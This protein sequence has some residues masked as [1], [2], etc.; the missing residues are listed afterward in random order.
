MDVEHR[1]GVSGAGYTSV[2][3]KDST[4]ALL[5]PFTRQRG[6]V[7]TRVYT[8]GHSNRSVEEFI[9]LLTA[10]VVEIVMDVRSV[11][12]S[13]HNPQFDIAALQRSLRANG[14]RYVHLVELGGFRHVSP[15]SP[16]GGWQNARFRGYADYMQTVEFAA[17]VDHLVDEARAA[18]TAIMCAEAV[19]WRCHRSLIADALLVRGTDVVDIIGPGP[20][21]PHRLTP[22][23]KVEGEMISYPAEADERGQ[24]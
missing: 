8:I 11:P 5:P 20:V 17:A 24:G 21:K 22:F 12:H 10:L 23:A 16:N 18:S 3:T 1:V 13:A 6:L 2:R 15:D 7:T 4:A 9:A 14:I 19:P